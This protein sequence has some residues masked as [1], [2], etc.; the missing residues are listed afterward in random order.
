MSTMFAKVDRKK[1][2]EKKKE[3]RSEKKKSGFLL[4]GVF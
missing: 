1:A 4:I 3:R 2:K